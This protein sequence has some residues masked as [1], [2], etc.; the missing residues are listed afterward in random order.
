MKFAIFR[1]ASLTFGIATMSACNG[2][3]DYIPVGRWE[4]TE[5]EE[6]YKENDH[7]LAIAFTLEKGEICAISD[8]VLIRKDMGYRKVSCA[9][10]SGWIFSTLHFRK[11]SD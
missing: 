10:G 6:V 9:Q 5:R 1:F 7:P 4:V 2:T 11:L 8:Q 3:H